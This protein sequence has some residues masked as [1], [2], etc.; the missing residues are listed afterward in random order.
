MS[1]DIAKLDEGR[2]EASEKEMG[3]IEYARLK[4]K[5]DFMDKFA[6]DLGVKAGLL[7]MKQQEA[8]K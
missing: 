1:Q 8:K 4:K 3:S 6:R 5:S 2:L 7:Y